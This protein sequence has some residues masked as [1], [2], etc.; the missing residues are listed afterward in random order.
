MPTKSHLLLLTA[1]ALVLPL[2]ACSS[3]TASTMG[4]TAGSSTSASPAAAGTKDADPNAGLKTGPQLAALL[5]PASAAPKGY[6]SVSSGTVNSGA[7]FQAPTTAPMD[8]SSVCGKLDGTAWIAAT[9]IGS[10]AFAQGD[11]MN[12]YQEEFSQE[13]DTFQGTGAQTTMARLRQIFTHCKHFTETSGSTTAHM[14]LTS[15]A[16]PGLGNQALEAVI[17][18]PTYK[19]G[20]T[21]VAARVGNTVVTTF[22]NVQ[23]SNLGSADLG[24]TKKIVAKIKAVG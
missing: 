8:L 22:Y 23:A 21:L 15:K 14:T 1:A 4:A 11:F 20:Q 7:G 13:I 10:Q 18:S 2:S 19:G 3:S 9:G 17:S 24:Y 16:I 6:K 12:A 5:L